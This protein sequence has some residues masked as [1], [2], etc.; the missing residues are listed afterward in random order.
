MPVDAIEPGPVVV[1]S[2]SRQ[3]FDTVVMATG[4]AAPP[5]LRATALATDERG[6]VLV[7]AG[8]RSVSHPEVFAAGDCAT[9]RDAPQPKSGVYSVRQGAT[10]EENLRNLVARAPLERYAPR[11]KAL[12]LIS[13]GEKYAIAERGS[14]TAEG[15]WIWRWKNWIDRRWMRSL[16]GK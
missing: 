5:W 11:A 3:E 15:A 1:S 13:C 16:N 10:L 12:A 2:A 7:D 8:L 9:L 6:F 4:A 14:W